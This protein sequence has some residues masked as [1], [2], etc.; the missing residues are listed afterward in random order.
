MPWCTCRIRYSCQ[1]WKRANSRNFQSHWCNMRCLSMNICP[2]ESKRSGLGILVQVGVLH[3]IW[4]HR[5]EDCCIWRG[6]VVPPPASATQRHIDTSIQLSHCA[7]G[8]LNCCIMTESQSQSSMSW[9]GDSV[10]SRSY[11]CWQMVAWCFW[12]TCMYWFLNFSG[13]KERL[14]FSKMSFSFSGVS[15]S[16]VFLTSLSTLQQMEAIYFFVISLVLQ[17]LRF[18]CKPNLRVS[19]RGSQAALTT[20]M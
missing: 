1:L 14:R 15:F 2:P 4:Q 13:T 11:L 20:G 3:S 19:S 10:H 12:I 16:L 17:S 5:M 8:I 7:S 9:G 6:T 18:F